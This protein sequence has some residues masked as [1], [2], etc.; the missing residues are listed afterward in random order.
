MKGNPKTR[1]VYHCAICGQK[2]ESPERN[3]QR[4]EAVACPECSNDPEI[5][6]VSYQ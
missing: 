3:V 2:L 6:A 4:H 5:Q 1:T